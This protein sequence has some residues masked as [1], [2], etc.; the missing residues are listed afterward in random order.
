MYA[1]EVRVQVQLTYTQVNCIKKVTFIMVS[2]F[3]QHRQLSSQRDQSFNYQ[4]FGVSCLLSSYPIPPYPQHITSYKMPRAHGSPVGS[5]FSAADVSAQSFD[6]LYH[7]DFTEVANSP[8][9]HRL[10]AGNTDL[11]GSGVPIMCDLWWVC[12]MCESMCNPALSPDRCPLC[13]HDKCG[14]CGSVNV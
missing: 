13:S 1:H 2:S 6:H 8:P 12:H 9:V 14:S 10:R 4:S 11:V 3:L 7:L 5:S